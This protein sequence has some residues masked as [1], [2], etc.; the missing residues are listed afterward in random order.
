LLNIV[1]NVQNAL[2]SIDEFSL[3]SGIFEQFRMTYSQ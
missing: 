3:P 2:L 1:K